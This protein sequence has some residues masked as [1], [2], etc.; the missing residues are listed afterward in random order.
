MAPVPGTWQSWAPCPAWFACGGTLG[1]YSTS[2]SP[3][4]LPEVV[5]LISLLLRDV[6]KTQFNKRKPKLPKPIKIRG[7]GAPT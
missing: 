3:H 2:L 5:G 6:V 1:A 7:D 4:F